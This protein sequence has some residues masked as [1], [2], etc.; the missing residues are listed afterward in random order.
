[1]LLW[2]QISGSPIDLIVGTERDLNR[3]RNQSRAQKTLEFLIFDVQFSFYTYAAP[4]FFQTSRFWQPVAVALIFLANI[5]CLHVRKS[6]EMYASRTWCTHA[7]KKNATEVTVC[8]AFDFAQR[9]LHHAGATHVVTV[10]SCLRNHL[11]SAPF[12]NIF[13]ALFSKGK[14]WDLDPRAVS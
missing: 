3:R 14:R 2:C 11:T 12:I 9:S 4:R 7:K 1:M 8:L 5:L 10:C 6:D 13:C